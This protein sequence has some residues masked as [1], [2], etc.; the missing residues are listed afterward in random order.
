MELVL[1]SVFI[2]PTN[3]G[4]SMLFINLKKKSQNRKKQKEILKAKTSQKFLVER[5]EEVR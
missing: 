2:L 3:L 1:I 4:T 5:S